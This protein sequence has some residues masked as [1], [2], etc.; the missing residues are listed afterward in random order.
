MTLCECEKATGSPNGL[1]CEKEGWFISNFERQGSWVG[2]KAFNI[3]E[4]TVL[5]GIAEKLT[6]NSKGIL[7]LP[8]R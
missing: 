8:H 7:R 2:C 1:S 4:I 6:E 5:R 3:C